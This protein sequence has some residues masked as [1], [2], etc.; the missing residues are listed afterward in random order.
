MTNEEIAIKLQSIED[1]SK[2]NCRRIDSIEERQSVIYDLATSVK[3]IATNQSS[4]NKK[5]DD[6]V[7]DVNELKSEPANRWKSLV[8]YIIAAIVSSGITFVITRLIA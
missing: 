5:L 1:R 2:S 8:G 7:K 4:M 6:V 3:I